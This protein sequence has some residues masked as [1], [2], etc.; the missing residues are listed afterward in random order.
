MDL[1]VRSKTVKATGRKL[2]GGSQYPGVRKL[3]FRK[4]E[5]CYLQKIS[6]KYD[7]S[8]TILISS[9]EHKPQARTDCNG[10]CTPQKP[11]TKDM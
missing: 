2:E 7:F 1:D 8:I 11:C 5:K 10:I 6:D 3:V 9:A 4:H